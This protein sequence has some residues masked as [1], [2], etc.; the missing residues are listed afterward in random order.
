MAPGDIHHTLDQVLNQITTANSI[1]AL[2]VTLRNNLPRETRDAILASSLSG[3]QDPL[4]VLDMRVNTLGVLYIMSA[5]LS[6]P[7]AHPPPHQLILE[8]CERFIPEQARFAPERMTLLA[9]GIA[10]YAE[11]SDRAAWAIAPLSNLVQRYPPHLSYLTSIHAVF[12]LTCVSTWHFTEALPILSVPITEIDTSLSDLNYND[13]LLYHYSGGIALAALKRWS[14]AEE[15]FE[16]CFTSPGTVPSAIQLEALKKWK[17]VQ[18]I[19]K[20]TAS[21]PPKYTHPHLPRLFKNTHYHAFASAYPHNAELLRTIFEKEKP[22]FHGE[23]NL[24]LI[25]QALDRAPRWALKKLTATYLTLGLADIGKA[26]KIESEEEVRELILSMIESKDISAKISADGAVTFYDP[27]PQ[28]TKDQVD[29]VLRDVQDQA[30]ALQVLDLEMG[31]SK[32][33]LNKAVRNREDFSGGG[34]EEIYGLLGGG[35]V[36][37]DPAMFS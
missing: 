23:K 33:F 26:V 9:R 30:G 2:S 34:E 25:Q 6:L 32:E 4:S 28:F 19:S 15:F 24:G 7:G 31:R 10:R 16:I 11:Q 17:L 22:Y 36:W 29:Q 27:P 5:R 1:A 37:E 21:N 20:G 12:L 3:G 13:N 35:A 14:E 18:L 8:F